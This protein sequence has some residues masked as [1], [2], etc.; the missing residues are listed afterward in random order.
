MKP[1]RPPV[2][3]PPAGEA[4]LLRLYVAGQAPNSGRAIANLKAI[5]KAH[6]PDRHRLEVVDV[7]ERPERALK[8]GILVT[9]TLLKLSPPPSVKIVGDLSETA[10]VLLALGVEGGAT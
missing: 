2:T 5:L 6:L 10:R 4:V 9:P 7:L 3:P 8:D 1:A